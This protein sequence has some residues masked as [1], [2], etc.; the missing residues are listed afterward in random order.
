MLKILVPDQGEIAY[1]RAGEAFRDMYEKVTGVTLEITDQ[2]EPG[3]D[4]VVIGSDAVNDFTAR[5]FAADWIDATAL[6]ERLESYQIPGT[7]FRE[8]HYRPT[9]G[10]M[11]GKLVHGVQ[12][13]FTD[14]AL[15]DVT[16]TQFY[17]LQALHELW[18]SRNPF[19][20]FA[21][22]AAMFDKVCGTDKVR[23]RFSASF[24]VADIRPLWT[25]SVKDF[26][27]LSAR[28]HLY[29]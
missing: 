7:M 19:Q 4:L 6:R 10:S 18:P 22:R 29:E 14:Y 1:L 21:G 5:A 26:R 23:E 2:Y 11:S 17:V 8:I 9:F 12:Y 28:Y 24:R 27:R 16:L 13:F 3:C 25:G 20:S 15:A